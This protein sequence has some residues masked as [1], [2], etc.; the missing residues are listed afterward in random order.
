MK[1]FIS[2]GFLIAIIFMAGFMSFVLVHE[3]THLALSDVPDGICLG[4]CEF[5]SYEREPQAGTSFA[6]AW[7]V[8]NEESVDQFVPN[9]FGLLA[10]MFV[11]V[12]GLDC[13]R[14][15]KKGEK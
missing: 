3:A 15:I 2:E 9:V 4:R 13:I 12:F 11:I 10:L 5:R 14:N 1:P 8:H 7:G 6:V